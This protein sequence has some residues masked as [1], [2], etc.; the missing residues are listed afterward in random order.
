MAIVPAGGGA[1]VSVAIDRDGQNGVFDV[2]WGTDGAALLAVAGAGSERSPYGVYR[3]PTAPGGA[4]AL[5]RE[6]GRGFD[7]TLGPGGR[8][9]AEFTDSGLRYHRGGVVFRDT[10]TGRVLARVAQAAAGDELYEA[11]PSVAFA[12][13]ASVAAV[14]AAIRV[15]GRRRARPRLQIVDLRSGRTVGPP[16][17]A[18]YGADFSPT[19]AGWPTCGAT[20]CGSSTWPRRPRS[21][22]AARARPDRL[23]R[24]LGP[25]RRRTVVDHGTSLDP[26]PL[27]GGW[28]PAIPTTGE[29][30]AALAWSPDGTRVAWATAPG[31]YPDLDPHH[32]ILVAD[33]RDPTVPPRTIVPP[34]SGAIYD[35]AFSPDG[36][37]FAFT[38]TRY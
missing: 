2:R 20:P 3:Y 27:S 14:T 19:G 38:R 35:L 36:T 30:V 5:V 16:L 34:R 22:S 12:P 4:R 13:D 33:P 1:P 18:A 17:P 28:R 15:P 25:G 10:G 23:P 26:A 37:R 8:V 31:T 21:A 7:L 9:L 24:R 29:E 32:A 6:L 11:A